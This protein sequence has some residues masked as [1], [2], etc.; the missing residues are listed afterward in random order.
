MPASASLVAIIL[1]T[2]VKSTLLLALAWGV[3]LVLKKRSAATQHMVRTFTLTAL[4]LL[5]F[6]A[7]LLPAWHVKGI[8][9]F[10]SPSAP[11]PQQMESRPAAAATSR[12]AVHAAPSW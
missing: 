7:I 3:A 8:P 9:E 11:V 12:L 4:L 2:A 5:P 1:D 10:S 6:S